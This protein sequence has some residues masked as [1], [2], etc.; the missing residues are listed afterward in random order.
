METEW[1]PIL[2][3][4][5]KWRK[6]KSKERARFS[7]NNNWMAGGREGEVGVKIEARRRRRRD[8]IMP[9]CYANEAPL[10]SSFSSFSS[11]SDGSSKCLLPC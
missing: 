3:R 7:N 11:S 5:E 8:G 9:M 6:K 2:K 1:K 10:C 4:I